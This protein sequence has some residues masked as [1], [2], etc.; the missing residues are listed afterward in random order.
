MGRLKAL[1]RTQGWAF[2]LTAAVA[3]FSMSVT[4]GKGNHPRFADAGQA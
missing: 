3:D 2:D 4:L 1:L